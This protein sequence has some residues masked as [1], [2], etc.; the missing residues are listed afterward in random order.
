MRGFTK[1]ETI[2]FYPTDMLGPHKAERMRAGE[3]PLG[4]LDRSTK[5]NTK[6]YDDAVTV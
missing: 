1:P 5:R 3:A 2:L 6:I 4:I